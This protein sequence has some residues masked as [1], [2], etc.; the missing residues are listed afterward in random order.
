MAM[1]E[2]KLG[3]DT[4]KVRG[5]YNPADHNY[6]VNV[7]IYQTTAFEM[8]DVDR[9]LRLFS[10]NEQAF[11]FLYTRVG[12]P[13]VAAYEQRV[14]LLDGAAGAV[15]LA[16]GMAAVSFTIFNLAEN[17]GRILS[18]PKLYGGTADSFK[19]IYPAFGIGID[20]PEDP[21]DPQSYARAIGS[22]TRAIFIESIS[23]P[24]STLLDIE[25]I[26]DVAHAHS[27]PL[28]V[29]NTFATPYLFRP[30][31]HGADIIVYS[32]TKHLNGHGNIIAGL[33]LES[34]K[35]D[36]GNGKFPQ[37]TEK[38]YTLRDVEGV[39]HS[40]LERFPDFPFTLRI[41]ATYLNYIGAPLSPF[42]AYLA[43]V[44]LET[45]SE[46]LDKQ[47]ANTEKL[48]RHLEGHERVAW[49]QHPYAAGNPYRALAA[50]YFPKG[51]GSIFTFGFKGTE[52]QSF[53]FLNAIRLLS[54]HPNV[55]DARTLIIN[56]PRTTHGELT[57]GEQRIAGLA[58][59]TIRISVGLEDAGD[60]IA[61]LEQA[62]EQAFA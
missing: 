37:F 41:R 49:V 60:L 2:K 32:G 4:L 23:N 50:R 14:S 8:G 42:D 36:W 39:E 55:G 13:T 59:E 17:G 18:T 11:P 6:A 53:R 56:S 45:L 9:A 26:A 44:G 24:N 47:R 35:F 38:H 20:Y 1:A 5:G 58:P 29:D 31:E 21:E 46:R 28:V 33:V 54:F 15:A 27:I 19:K 43:L 51:A 52:E 40:F 3:F 22:D 30:F 16:S 57:P 62:F 7:P 61:D 25:A 34:G 10:F 12:N 48:I